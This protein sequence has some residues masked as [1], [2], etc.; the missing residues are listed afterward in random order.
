MLR[1]GSAASLTRSSFR[2][3]SSPISRRTSTLT[4]VS[5]LRPLVQRNLVPQKPSGLALVLRQ[6]LSTSLQRYA[7]PYD[8][9]NYE[10]EKEVGQRKLVA[11]PEEVSD[12]SSVHEVFHEKGVEEEEK[13]EDM[14]AGVK[15]DFI[16]IKETFA[17]KEVPREALVIGLAGVLP[18]LATSLST[19]YL[20]FDINHVGADGS[21]FFFSQPTAEALLHIIEPLQIGYG[22]VILSFL[23]AIHWGLEW[24]KYGGEHGYRRYA[25]GVVAPAV[26]WPTILFPVEYALIS[27]FCAFTFLYFADANAVVNGWAPHWYSTYRFVLTFIVGASIVATLIGRG[28]IADQI[29]RLP[30]PADR[31]KQLRD[32]QYQAAEEEERAKRARI[33]AEG[34][35]EED[36]DEDDGDEEE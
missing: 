1:S 10:R 9:P 22:A 17:L 13:D 24:A 34:E 4:G 6:P 28:Q 36:E 14:L 27:Q 32:I 31:V 18:Y 7:G 8:H 33:I 12:T 15:A 29:N 26:A 25:Y 2:Y 11:V 5:R 21:N 20:A 19:V 35:G 16:T 3:V 30:S 23:G